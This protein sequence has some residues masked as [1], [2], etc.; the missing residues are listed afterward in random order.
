[1]LVDDTPPGIQLQSPIGA[2]STNGNF[3]NDSPVSVPFTVSDN[4]ACNSLSVTVSSG[5]TVSFNNGTKSGIVTFPPG[6]TNGNATATVT[7][8]DCSGNTS[9]SV[10]T[11]P[12]Q[13]CFCT[14]TQGGWG[15][16]CS[17]GNVGCTR[18]AHF[19][20]VYNTNVVLATA[21]YVAP[22]MAIGNQSTRD[23]IFNAA[24]AI[25]NYL[26]NNMAPAIVSANT[27]NAVGSKT[28]TYGGTLGGN[29]LALR[30]SIDFDAKNFLART[31]TL[32]LGSLVLT[33]GPFAGMSVSGFESLAEQVLA[34]GALPTG[35]SLSTFSDT[36]SAV[37]NN[38]DGCRGN[39]GLLARPTA[40]SSQ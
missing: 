9:Q 13:T 5:A 33:S 23:L 29:L 39:G 17:G 19:G 35:T 18:D 37:N 24:R 6:S 3:C 12:E 34:G 15:A 27:L 2:P 10:V 8:T 38:F 14:Y 20:D 1:V 22:A 28:N 26:P 16:G 32:P 31:T 30:L 21:T 11:V 40:V 7:I 36:L 4:C 25:D